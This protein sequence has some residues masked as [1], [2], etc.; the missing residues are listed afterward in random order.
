MVDISPDLHPQVI[1]TFGGK[2]EHRESEIVDAEEFIAK[3]GI[4]AKGKKCSPYDL[5]SVAF[6]EPLHKPEDDIEREEPTVAEGLEEAMEVD[7]EADAIGTTI[8][9]TGQSSDLLADARATPPDEPGDD[10]VDM[11][12]W[13]PTLF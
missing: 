7:V 9:Q 3:K 12:G 13:E 2:Y 6:G 5:K 1:L 11:G 10:A 4:T 8:E